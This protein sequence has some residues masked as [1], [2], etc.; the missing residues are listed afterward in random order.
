MGA[1]VGERF[2]SLWTY[3]CLTYRKTLLVAL[4]ALTAVTGG[5]LADLRFENALEIWFLEDDPALVMHRRL[6]ETFA[7]DELMV[8]GLEAPDVFAPEVLEAIDRVTRAIED[9]PNVEKVFSLT[10]VEA[11]TSK[12]DLLDV[13]PL[14]EIPLDPGALPAIRERALASELYAGNVVSPD[15]RFAVIVARLP[16]P[17]DA[18]QKGESVHT[19]QAI[20]DREPGIAFYVAGGPTLDARLFE[21]SQADSARMIGGMLLL[22]SVI[23]WM[24]MRTV[25]GV[26]LP[27]AT[28]ILATIWMLGA[29]ALAGVRTNVLTTL[30]PPL[31]LAIG[32]ADA[33]HVLVEYQERSRDGRG[34]TAA[35]TDVL[36][37][38]FGP[39]FLASVTTAIGMLSLTVSRIAGIRQ[40]GAFAALGIAGA[41]LLSVTFVPI[42][43]SYLPV[44]RPR[45]G[46][47]R[48]WLSAGALERVHA[49]TLR[50]GRTIVA[51]TFVA[52]VLAVVGASRIRSESAFIEMFKP[53]APIRIATERIQESMGG[54]VTMDVLVDT[55]REGG[56]KDPAVLEKLAALE[57]FLIVQP[58]VTSVQSIVAYLKTMRRAFFDGDPHQYRLPEAAAET[59]QYLL[60][61]EMDAPDGDLNEFVA[62]DYRHARVTARVALDTSATAVELL[63][64]TQQYLAREFPDDVDAKV[65]GLIAMY[66]GMH[67][68]IR[69]SLVQGF[70]SALVLIFLVFCVQ[71]RSVALGAIVMLANSM[72]IVLTLGIMGATGIRLDSMTV[73]V[74]SITIGL[75]DDDSIH[76]V[77]RV[78]SRLAAG[79]GIESALHDALVEVGRALV[80]TGLALC[81]G[82]AVMLSA[83]FMPAVY[84]GLLTMLTIVI[85]L[86]SDLLFL[87]V[88]LR[89]HGGRAGPVGITSST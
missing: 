61:Y 40:F 32:V 26:L 5:A 77:S 28:V 69:D 21:Q 48:P 73:M 58:H 55:G 24:L 56:V 37:E 60:L 68:Y 13:S 41:F 47:K 18:A 2:V 8:V 88:L 83:G 89:W 59:A 76:F 80:Y 72:P 20:L 82:F 12:G 33:M 11:I 81:A 19:I 10:N 79:A 4:A 6:V 71:M 85:A 42:A 30:L 45:S 44:P 38:L 64:I 67:E 43:L 86:V 29:M 27:L 46:Q 25:A 34:K 63:E 17:S 65:A 36:R 3:V 87:P 49:F 54:T 22:L 70:G 31:L 78:R 75:V 66:A 51:V 7:S 52:V 57:S 35:L 62:S 1:D 9:A 14:I 15:G 23:L 39:L 50:R 16:H 84:F 53:A 74:A